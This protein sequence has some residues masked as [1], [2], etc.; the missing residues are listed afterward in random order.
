MKVLGTSLQVS[1]PDHAQFNQIALLS[2]SVLKDRKNRFR[3]NV[4]NILQRENEVK[5]Q[6]HKYINIS[7]MVEVG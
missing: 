3:Q 4:V 6:R 1:S 5:S 7:T 2:S